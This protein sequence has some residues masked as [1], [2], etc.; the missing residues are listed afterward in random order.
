M[1]SNDLTYIAKEVD[2]ELDLLRDTNNESKHPE[3]QRQGISFR[4]AGEILFLASNYIHVATLLPCHQ[5]RPVK[6]SLIPAEIKYDSIHPLIVFFRK[7]VIA[8]ICRLF[9]L[10]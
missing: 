2:R 6:T 10:F 8:I 4:S 9:P 3:I 5:M 7:T 1:E